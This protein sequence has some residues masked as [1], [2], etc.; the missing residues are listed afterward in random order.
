MS[1]SRRSPWRQ[2]MAHYHVFHFWKFLPASSSFS[3][4]SDHLLIKDSLRKH[5]FFFKPGRVVVYI[6]SRIIPRLSLHIQ[7]VGSVCLSSATENKLTVN[8]LR[9]LLLHVL[10]VGSVCLWLCYWLH[11]SS[12]CMLLWLSVETAHD[13]PNTISL[14]C[15]TLHLS[16]VSGDSNEVQ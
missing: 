7:P 6:A 12:E 13:H 1:L 8:A 9:L 4:L 14:C 5:L 11:T 16:L 15:W 3:L 2:A 10:P